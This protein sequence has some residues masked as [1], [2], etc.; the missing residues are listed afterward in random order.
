[1]V[2][3]THDPGGARTSAAALRLGG[4]FVCVEVDDGGD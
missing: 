2:M 3:M 4:Q 1:M